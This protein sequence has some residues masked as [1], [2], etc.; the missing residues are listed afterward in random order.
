MFLLIE[1][2]DLAKLGRTDLFIVLNYFTKV[3]T[4]ICNVFE[5][6]ISWN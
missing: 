3:R 2:V 6:H 4:T 1:N 5:I